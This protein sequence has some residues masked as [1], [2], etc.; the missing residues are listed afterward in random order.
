MQSNNIPNIYDQDNKKIEDHKEIANVM[1]K[2]FC[3]IGSEVKK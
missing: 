3:E 1:N 2:Y